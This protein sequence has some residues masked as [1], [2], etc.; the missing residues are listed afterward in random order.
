LRVRARAAVAAFMRFGPDH[1]L[2]FRPLPDYAFATQPVLH[3][4]S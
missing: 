2:E 1:Y 3:A 4:V